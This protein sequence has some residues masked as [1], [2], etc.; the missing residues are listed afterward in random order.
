MSPPD[1]GA[2]Y[3]SG[4]A[5]VGGAG[6]ESPIPRR[7]GETPNPSTGSPIRLSSQGKET[8]NKGRMRGGDAVVPRG[9]EMLDK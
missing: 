2:D 6:A 8:I 5:G 3:W 7:K 4:G 1:A 9:G